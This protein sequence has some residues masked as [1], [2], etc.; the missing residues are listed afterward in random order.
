MIT[1]T[2]EEKK[3]LYNHHYGEGRYWSDCESTN[4]R[5]AGRADPNTSRV[6]L[7]G[8]CENLLQTP[9][10]WLK[11]AKTYES[12]KIQRWKRAQLFSV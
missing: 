3:V 12:W 4:L 11:R 7:D 10:N 1:L 5:L 6:F 8:V 9:D 2:K